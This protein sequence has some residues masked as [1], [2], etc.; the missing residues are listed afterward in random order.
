MPVHKTTVFHATCDE[1]QWA[2]ENCKW[3]FIAE[4]LLDSH[5]ATNH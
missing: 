4:E 1:C 3:S 2:S 5:I